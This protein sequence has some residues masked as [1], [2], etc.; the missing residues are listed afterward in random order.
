[1]SFDDVDLLERLLACS[2]ADLDVL[3]FGVIGFDA[4]AI[5]T[6]YNAPEARW[7]GLVQGDVIGTNMFEIVAP[8]MNNFL[9][10]E[11]FKDA[12]EIEGTMDETLEYVLT[13]RMRPTP[14]ILR[15]LARHGILT[16]YILICRKA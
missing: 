13:L 1:M 7:A 11:Q 6:T 15:L 3:T 10:A 2:P 4:E 5:V 14:V 9:I 12:L 8:C 16:R